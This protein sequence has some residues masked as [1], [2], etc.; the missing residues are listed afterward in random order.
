ME[1]EFEFLFQSGLKFTFELKSEFAFEVA[2]SS[3]SSN[4][5]LHQFI[6]PRS[7][8]APKKL[9]GSA[10]K[11]SLISMFTSIWSENYLSGT[12]NGSQNDPLGGPNGTPLGISDLGGGTDPKVAIVAESSPQ[13]W[14]PGAEWQSS[15]PPI[16][17]RHLRWLT[18]QLQLD[19]PSDRASVIMFI[20][21]TSNRGLVITR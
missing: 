5:L 1:F 12:Q 7:C 16:P 17:P 21:E 11:Q 20:C 10:K 3:W 14:G 13:F 18:H 15:Y 19:Y 9:P 6:S 8:Q 4:S 2:R